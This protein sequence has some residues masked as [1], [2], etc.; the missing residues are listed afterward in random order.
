MGLFNFITKFF[1]RTE[2]PLTPEQELALREQMR[3]MHEL[4]RHGEQGTAIPRTLPRGWESGVGGKAVEAH[5]WFG[6]RDNPS[7]N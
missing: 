4:Q 7:K 2:V 5:T 3:I 6:P 1:K